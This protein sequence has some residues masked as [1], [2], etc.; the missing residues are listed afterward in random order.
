MS[1]TKYKVVFSSAIKKV[2]ISKEEQ[3]AKASLNELK[4]FIPDIDERKVDFLG[5]ATSAYVVNHCNMNGVIVATKEALDT[6]DMFVYSPINLEHQRSRIVGVILSSS[7]SEFGSEKQLKS[8]D[9]KGTKDPFNITLGGVIW[10]IVGEELIEYLEETNNPESENYQKVSASFEIGFDDYDIAILPPGTRNLSEGKI[11][12]EEKEKSELNSKL[13][14]FGGSG[15]LDDGSIVAMVLKGN[16][17]PLG[18]GLTENPAA[19]VVGIAVANI[20]P[21]NPNETEEN[22]KIKPIKEIHNINNNS[23]N[24]IEIISQLEKDNVNKNSKDLNININNTNLIERKYM[25]ITSLKEITDDSLKTLTASSVVD[26]V[27]TELKTY[28]EKWATEK[29]EK[30]KLIQEASQKYA[31]LEK[32][33]NDLAEQLKNVKEQLATFEKEKQESIAKELFN[34][35]MAKFD[36]VYELTN[37]DR[38]AIASR[39]ENITN[40]GFDSLFKDMEILLKEK[41]KEVIAANKLKEVKASNTS[42]VETVVETVLQN[43]EKVTPQV[44]NAT[45]PAPQTLKEKYSN[46]F[47]VDQFDIVVRKK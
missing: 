42:T 32:T 14:T 45:T 47:A 23:D 34:Q 10:K 12:N 18:I 30:D 43:A 17:I 3:V 33:Y 38:K 20:D 29:A 21:E 11:V 25:K 39:I 35:R 36:E 26:F 4:K 46:A 16:V 41:N 6:M 44:P 1:G 5:V 27:E 8:G 15:K 9:V 2:P 13:Q 40:E 24:K 31:T 22:S 28:S 19:S 7:I 37:D